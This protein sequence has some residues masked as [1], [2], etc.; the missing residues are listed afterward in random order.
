MNFD[1]TVN[2]EYQ[3]YAMSK[4]FARGTNYEMSSDAEWDWLD[5][6]IVHQGDGKFYVKST[7]FVALDSHAETWSSTSSVASEYHS[8]KY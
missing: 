8:K 7:V 5:E 6:H 2:I 4:L 1:D 3:S